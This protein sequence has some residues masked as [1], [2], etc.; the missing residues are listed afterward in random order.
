MKRWMKITAAI[1]LVTL[2]AT[3]C[4]GWQ[5][6]TIETADQ[7]DSVIGSVDQRLLDS[8][9]DVV[10][11]LG[12]AGLALGLPGLGLAARGV[13][14][15]RALTNTVRGFARGMSNAK[16]EDS[17]L[18]DRLAAN[19]DIIKASMDMKSIEILNKARV[20]VGDKLSS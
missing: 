2:V 4:A 18:E 14:R 19:K 5:E 11:L 17:V 16:A 3:G 13:V 6:Q 8:G 7:V 1:L 15:E 20:E 10:G 12:Y 9:I